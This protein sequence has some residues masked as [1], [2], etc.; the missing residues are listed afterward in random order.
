MLPAS[1]ASLQLRSASKMKLAFGKCQGSAVPCGGTQTPPPKFFLEKSGTEGKRSRQ[2]EQLSAPVPTINVSSHSFA[3]LLRIYAPGQ[4]IRILQRAE[5]KGRRLQ[6]L[7]RKVRTRVFFLWWSDF[8]QSAL[9]GTSAPARRRSQL[10]GHGSRSASVINGTRPAPP[11]DSPICHCNIA[12]Q[13]S[14]VYWEWPPLLGSV[15]GSSHCGHL[16]MVT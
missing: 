5:P 4:P 6:N 11:T 1:R 10:G 9:V 3:E 13:S 12:P 15:N 7:R 8:G 14:H 2:P 16:N